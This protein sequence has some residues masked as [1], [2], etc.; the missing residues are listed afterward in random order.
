M[1]AEGAS[2]AKHRTSTE[3]L[4]ILHPF[5]G[6]HAATDAATRSFRKRLERSKSSDSATLEG[7]TSQSTETT[8]TILVLPLPYRRPF[9]WR[10]ETAFYRYLSTRGLRLRIRLRKEHPIH[11]QHHH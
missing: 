10:R 5:L 1:K 4:S 7:S 6:Q 9:S 8:N 3:D 11:R 2:R